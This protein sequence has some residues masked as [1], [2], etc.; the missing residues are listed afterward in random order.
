MHR[1]FGFLVLLAIAGFGQ[2]K[3]AAKPVPPPAKKTLPGH[4]A[5]NDAALE[6]DIRARFT[7]SKISIDKFEVKVQGGVATITGKTDVLQHKGVATRLARSAG[8][9][10]VV[11]KVEVSDAA[12]QQASQNLASGG[13][14]AQVKRSEVAGRK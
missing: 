8:A 13:R 5:S 10:Q 14:R 12:K 2:T 7:R 11:N 3:P 9:A 6:R 1:L 4:T